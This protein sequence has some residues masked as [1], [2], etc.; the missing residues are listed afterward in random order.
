MTKQSQQQRQ[1]HIAELIFA[2]GIAR[3]DDLIE[4][5]DVSPMTL[6]RDLASLEA[7]KV[8]HRS[9]GEVS[10]VAT[11]MSETPVSFRSRQEVEAKEAVAREAARRL[12]PHYSIFC[13]DSTTV[14]TTI[15]YLE[16]TGQKTFITNSLSISREISAIDHA[17]LITLGGR[18]RHQLDAF[19]GPM[20]NTALS[21][22]SPNVGIFGTAAIKDNVLYHPYAEVAA[23]KAAS[24]AKSEVSILLV[25]T[26]K[27]QRTS[28]YK[29]A[30]VAD[31]NLVIV[32]SGVPAPVIESMEQHTTVVVAQ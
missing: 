9:R 30:S 3:V 8:I 20:T 5:V 23:F 10:A 26:S 18:Y 17:A 16:D 7:R 32:D 6:Y 28:L 29:M 11:S 19:F 14:S 24:I 22:L 15:P 1:D 21:G 27:F 25:T 13:D 12:A 2:R 31:F 4:L